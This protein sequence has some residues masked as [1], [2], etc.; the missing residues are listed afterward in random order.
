MDA[1]KHVG[2]GICPLD[3]GHQGAENIFVRIHR[4]PEVGAVGVKGAD[5]QADGHAGEQE[6]AQPVKIVFILKK[7]VHY[8]SCHIEKPEQIRDDEVLV[9][10][11]VIVQGHMDDVVVACHGSLQIE[12]PGNIQE[13]V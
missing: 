6:G 12:K 10:R 7:E 3:H 11:N 4:R 8:R 1:G 5:N 2:T 13:N 9:K